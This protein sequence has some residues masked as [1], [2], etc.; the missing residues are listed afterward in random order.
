MR[1]VSRVGLAMVAAGVMLRP[2][3][4]FAQSVPETA[5][6]TPAT[7]AVG[8]R[9]L[10][11]FSLNGTVT[12]SAD[13]PAPAAVAPIR[14]RTQPA[15]PAGASTATAVARDAPTASASRVSSARVTAAARS[16][17]QSSPGQPLA[18]GFPSP[19][20]AAPTSTSQ[21]GFAPEPDSAPTTFASEQK[22][23]LWPWL[24]LA[25]VIGA[26]GA[27]LFLR[28]RRSRE[29][30]AGDAEIDAYVA[31]EPAPQPAPAPAP[32]PPPQAPPAKAPPAKPAGVVSTRLR[33]WI[34][35]AFAPLGCTIDEDRV[36]LE[37]EVQLTNSGSA[38]ARDILVEASMF[39]AGA[40]QEQ[41]IGAFFSQ[42]LGQG[43][44]IETIP[45]L[46]HVNIRTSLV[47]PRQNIQIFELGGHQVFV[48]LVA[49]NAIYRGGSG[50]GQTSAAYLVGRETKGEKLG[51]LRA[52]IGP[53][54]FARLD[55]RPLPISV[56]K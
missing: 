35:I 31:P 54:A 50:S 26:G 38:P 51:P 55:T 8:P 46:Q 34:E 27:L 13:T 15:R 43:E 12:K 3:P 48:P 1:A 41:D 19:T 24:L 25:G 30:Y 39:N 7:D 32:A 4:A 36:T 2:V 45:P 22:V 40:T 5:T 14:S 28:R 10:Q 23:T 47:A 42:P 29:A 52:D 20:T 44:N 18:L 17:A 11:N 9:E 37:F 21:P 33:P 56:R 6:N 49:F 53:H 16:S